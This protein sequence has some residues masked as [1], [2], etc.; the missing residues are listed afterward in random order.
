VLLLKTAALAVGVNVVGNRRAFQP[1]RGGENIDHRSVQANGALLAQASRDG[2][3]M[4]ARFIQRLIGVN[5]AHAA[6]ESLIQQQRLDGGASRL[7]QLPKLVE[8]DAERVGTERRGPFGQFFAPFDAAEM[9]DV[10][11]NQQ[12]AIEFENGA[13]VRAGFG[14]EQQLSRHAQMDHQ[15]APIERENDKL[16]VALHG[17]YKLIANSLAQRREFLAHHVV[18]EELGVDNAPPCQLR[19]ECSNYRFNFRQLRHELR[20]RSECHR[21][22]L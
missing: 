3:R 13:R 21:R 12:A 2:A 1:N 20:D 8:R 5:I 7:Q 17:F 14:I 15:H 4:D 9:A 11:I 10:V 6:Q 19:R 18:R 16:A 22:R